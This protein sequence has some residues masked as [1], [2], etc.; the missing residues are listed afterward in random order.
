MVACGVVEDLPD[1][2]QS[3]FLRDDEEARAAGIRAGADV[4]MFVEVVV[5][6][7]LPALGVPARRTERTRR[8]SWP[9][10][11][12]PGPRT[13]ATAR[14]RL[15]TERPSGRPRRLRPGFRRGAAGR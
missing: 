1:S 2:P 6:H 9:A 12:C 14:S 3:R 5:Q 15:P 7:I 10:R 13:W 11:T 4:V 8:S